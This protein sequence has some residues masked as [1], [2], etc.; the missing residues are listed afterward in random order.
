MDAMRNFWNAASLLAGMLVAA[1]G[2]EA[3]L[4]PNR[5]ID[6]GVTGISMLLAELTGVSLSIWLVVVNAPFV[7]LGYRSIG[8]LFALKSS[9]AILGLAGALWVLP[10]PEATDDK[11]LGAV[12]GGFFIGAGVGLAIR[13]GGV[14]DGTEI[15]AVIL[16]KKI[17]T[18]VGEVILGLNV[19]IF[20]AAA[21]LLGI[22]AAMYSAL[23]YFAASKTIN[24][25]LHGIEAYN[26]VMIF[27]SQHEAIRQAILTELERGVTV[28]PAKGGYTH[29]EQ[30][31]L[32]C[33]VTRLEISRLETIVKRVDS[34]AFIVVSPVH[35]TSGGVVKKRVFH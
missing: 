35:E 13:G 15:L 20:S 33:V 21:M 10:F 4:L 24:F 28:F 19:V 1:L 17:F 27:S 5:F 22:E 23:T 25:L 30:Q 14:L 34:H 26:G 8:R 7:W 31:V 11:L 32:F 6:G 29:A 2:I 9:L 12:F 16:S 18:T 3:F